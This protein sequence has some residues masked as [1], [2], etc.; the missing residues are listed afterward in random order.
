MDDHPSIP[1]PPL[2]ASSTA[3][4]PF[5]VVPSLFWETIAQDGNTICSSQDGMVK[6]IKPIMEFLF[7]SRLMILEEE[8]DLMLASV[9]LREAY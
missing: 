4:T 3:E 8:Y 5:G 2:P 1:A 6:L 9:M 7:S